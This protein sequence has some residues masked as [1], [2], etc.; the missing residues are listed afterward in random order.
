MNSSFILVMLTLNGIRPIKEC[1]P[2]SSAHQ[3]FWKMSK[4]KGFQTPDT[5]VSYEIG[6][7]RK[8]RSVVKKKI[9]RRRLEGGGGSFYII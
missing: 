4:A 5:D 1:P 9:R 6:I 7:I 8:K 2:V 3:V